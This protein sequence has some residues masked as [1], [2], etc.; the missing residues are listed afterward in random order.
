L[1]GT[2]TTGA[3][4]SDVV[5]VVVVVVSLLVVPSVDV[6][7]EDV[8]VEEELLPGSVA[9]CAPALVAHP[10]AVEQSPSTKPTRAAKS[11]ADAD[12]P[13]DN[14]VAIEDTVGN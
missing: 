11:E 3:T 10:T 12:E 14:E 6:P 1:L 9:V 4:G 2:S 13:R 8:V 5:V 7:V